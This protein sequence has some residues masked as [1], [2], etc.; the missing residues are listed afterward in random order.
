MLRKPNRKWR[1]RQKIAL[2][3]VLA[4][5]PGCATGSGLFN[6]LPGD[7][8]KIIPCPPLVT[9]STEQR[10]QAAEELEAISE[11]GMIERFLLDYVRLR[12]QIRA[13]CE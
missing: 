3:I 6:P 5:L 11:L 7:D 2:L 4:S 13:G 8:V 12:D 1:G 9:Y 10:D